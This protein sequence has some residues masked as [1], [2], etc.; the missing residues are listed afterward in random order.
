MIDARSLVGSRDILF[1]T[2]DALR[3]DV[4][5]RL[6]KEGRTPTLASHLGPQGWEERHSPASFTYAAHQAFFTGF[7]PTPARPAGHVRPFALRFPG[8]RSTGSGTAIFDSPDIVSGLA[9]RGYR[10]VCIGG[11]GF[12][13]KGNPLGAV[14]PAFFQ[15]SHWNPRF[16]V[17]EE[18]STEHQVALACQL[19][20]ETPLE[21]R[22]FLFINISAIHSPNRMY[23]EHAKE[24]S[25]QSHAAALEYVDS[26]LPP[27][28]ESLKRRGQTFCILCSDHGTTYGE[29]GHEGHRIAHP[30]V[31]TV[32][33]AEFLLNGRAG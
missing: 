25:L 27:L 6:W 3:Y 21:K 22:I 14:L 31:W 32:P 23:L 30:A 17:N 2:F 19:L 4:A 13:N 1:L 7:F 12:F 26:K 16:G 29:D 10:T 5:Q 11:V 24:D 9:A 20:K 8:S 28:F 33:Y 15:E 18:R